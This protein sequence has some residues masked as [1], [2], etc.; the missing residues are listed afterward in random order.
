M[1]VAKLTM[2]VYT[3]AQRQ[4]VVT[5]NVVV[6]LLLTTVV[7]AASGK[8]VPSLGPDGL[9]LTLIHLFVSGQ[10]GVDSGGEQLAM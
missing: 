2:A 5:S 8:P 4:R 6:L 7:F 10:T 1:Y 3:S 9:A